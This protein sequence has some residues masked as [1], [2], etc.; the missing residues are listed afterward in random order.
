MWQFVQFRG[1]EY[2][3]MQTPYTDDRLDPEKATRAAAHHLRDLYNEFGDWYLAMAAYNCGPGGV[4]KAVERTGYASFWELRDRNVLPRETANYVP[5]ILAMTIVA[6]NPKA[7][8]LESVDPDPPLAADVV[9]LTAPTHLDLVADLVDAPVPQLRELNPAL[10]RSIAPAGYA[11]R[12]PRG[13]AALV[14]SGLEKVPEANRISWRAHRIGEGETMA[15][16]AQRF[17]VNSSTLAAANQMLDGDLNPGDLVIVPAVARPEVAPRRTAAA[18]RSPARRRATT[19]TRPAASSKAH[20][21]ATH[22]TAQKKAPALT[23]SNKLPKKTQAAK[24]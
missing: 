17:K 16:V 12:I 2:G 10:L 14:T 13:T 22:A 19:T 21:A 15:S 11:L 8:G 1:Q 5:I 7:Y 24:Q 3:L 20:P 4:Q 6:K 23:A 9:E 18:R